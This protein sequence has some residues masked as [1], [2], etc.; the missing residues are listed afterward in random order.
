MASDNLK[1]EELTAVIREIQQ[2]VRSRH[3]TGKLGVGDIPLPDLMPVVHARDAADA[4][5]AAIGTVNPRPGGLKNRVIQT[6]K[7]F[8]SRALDWHVREQV[9]FNRAA[10]TCVQA[11]LDALEE[12]NR[13]MSL[14]AGH[15]HNQALEG[16]SEL[17]QEVAGVDARIAAVDARLHAM[18]ARL[19]GAEAEARELKDIRKYWADWR[20]AWEDKLNRSEVYMLRSISELTGSFQHRL[21]VTEASFRQTVRE[22]HEG[23]EG[24]LARSIID[25]QERLWKDL[26]RSR[27]DYDRMIHDELRIIRQRAAIHGVT[28]APASQPLSATAPNEPQIDW[29]RFASRFRGSEDRVRAGQSLYIERF[30]GMVD[31]LDLGCGRGEFLEAA[32]QAGI[33][34]RGIDLS[35]EAVAL[36]RSK[37]L[38]AE[39]A[40]LFEYLGGLADGALGGVYCSQVIEHLPPAR[41][42]ELARL[43]A[44]KLRRDGLVAFETPNPECLAIFASHFYLDPTHIRPIPPPLLVFVLEECGFGQIE[45]KR[46]SPAVDDMPSLKELPEDFRDAF[47]GGLDYALFAKK[48]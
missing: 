44:A 45:V 33:P 10:M 7:K 15:F 13:A 30:A 47:F 22:Q 4:K 25:I 28:G 27:A 19:S 24:A 29:F 32:K 14:M 39:V 18:G 11:I 35:E 9:E 23:F 31:V 3:P 41:L 40:D 42:P 48:L 46:L 21:T 6:V 2:R 1:T 34:A 37:G 5:V 26:D 8:V 38:D 17:M 16:R 12:S 36:C 43:I 20:A